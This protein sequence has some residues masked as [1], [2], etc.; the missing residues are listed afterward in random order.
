MKTHFLGGLAVLGVLFCSG[1]GLCL[2]RI[3]AGIVDARL[4][5]EV[6]KM[7]SSTISLTMQQEEDS[8]QRLALF[9]RLLEQSDSVVEM[10]GQGQ[11]QM[12]ETEIRDAA[13]LTLQELTERLAA[14]GLPGI[15]T[16]ETMKI[17]PVL[18]VGQDAQ[19]ST[20]S[21]VFWR[22]LF[23]ENGG[24]LWLDDQTGQMVGFAVDFY[25][26]FLPEDVT[27]IGQS[28]ASKA[29]SV[30]MVQAVDVFQEQTIAMAQVFEQ[31]CRE[32]YTADTVELEKAE[33][34]KGEGVYRIV[35]KQKKDN[36]EQLCNIPLL[37]RDGKIWFNLGVGEK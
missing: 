22:I 19:K 32:Y 24:C 18:F 12:T 20:R 2:P 16:G 8:L 29:G 11:Y 25:E 10:S 35:M 26:I 9:G 28:N 15:L 36:F 17:Q 13:R 21:A 14:Y 7:E 31:Y 1:F 34:D 37:V 33:T 23:S 27:V 4:Q 5:T 3:A 30:D 6:R